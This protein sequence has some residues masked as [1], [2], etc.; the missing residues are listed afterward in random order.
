MHS[1][2]YCIHQLTRQTVVAS[3]GILMQIKVKEGAKQ[4]LYM[5]YAAS[6]ISVND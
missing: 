4:N 3:T 6:W 5:Y 1:Y 2:N